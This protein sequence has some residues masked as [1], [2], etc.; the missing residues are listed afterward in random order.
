ML[1]KYFKD[2]KASKMKKIQ[3][4]L[5]YMLHFFIAALCAATFVML[6]PMPPSDGEITYIDK[7]VHICIFMM[8][9]ILGALAYLSHKNKVWVSLVGYGILIEIMQ[10][11]LTT[12]RD[13]DPVDLL[14]DCIGILLGICVVR[15]LLSFGLLKK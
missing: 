10:A 15:M 8:L 6:M 4:P 3:I 13:G 14:A 9:A 12:T 1:V 11:T 2:Y 5:T 7:L